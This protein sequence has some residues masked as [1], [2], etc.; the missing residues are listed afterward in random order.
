ME[1]NSSSPLLTGKHD[2]T[3]ATIEHAPPSSTVK[4]PFLDRYTVTVFLSYWTSLYLMILSFIHGEEQSP[5]KTHCVLMIISIVAISLS[6]TSGFLIYTQNYFS[7]RDSHLTILR[8]ISGFS[9]PLSNA[10]LLLVFALP[11]NLDWVGYLLIFVFFGTAAMLCFVCWKNGL[12]KT[13]G[14][15]EFDRPISDYSTSLTPIPI[16][17]SLFIPI[18]FFWI[19][20]SVIVGTILITI[21]Y[22]LLVYL[23]LRK[24][25]RARNLEV[26]PLMQEG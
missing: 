4:P 6:L 18:K 1:S 23:R 3:R 2:H 11:E 25:K 19:K 5:F 16:A 7:P 8:A 21:V 22:N 26:H 12:F 13:E 10:S 24:E 9:G 14:L 17:L 20:L 15:K